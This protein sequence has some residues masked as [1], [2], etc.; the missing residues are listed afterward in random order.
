[1][2]WKKEIYLYSL[3][4]GSCLGFVFPQM[5]VTDLEKDGKNQLL[6]PYP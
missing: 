4:K 2:T 6:R 3:W 5:T 1:M